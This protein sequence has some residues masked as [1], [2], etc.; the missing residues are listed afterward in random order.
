MCYKFSLWDIDCRSSTI[1]SQGKTYS[2]DLHTYDSD[3]NLT[4]LR[5]SGGVQHVVWTRLQSFFNIR[6]SIDMVQQK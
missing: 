2:L 3:L 5:V 1:P 4:Q 6:E